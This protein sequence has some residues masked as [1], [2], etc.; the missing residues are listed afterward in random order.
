M[1]LLL[2][3]LAH[4]DTA[5]TDLFFQQEF[6]I[7]K[8]L[9]ALSALILLGY[10]GIVA[11]LYLAQER[12]IYPGSKLPP[13]YKFSFDQPFKEVQIAVPGA[14][15]NALHIM[16]PAP[17]GLL[18]FIHGNGGDL[19]TWTTGADFYR[20]VNYDLF[21]FDYRGYGKSTGKIQSEAQ[22]HADVRAAWDAI[23]PQ[24]RDRNI[25]IVVYGRSLGTGLAVQLAREVDPA[26]LILVSSYT[27]LLAASKR[28]YAIAP[29]WILKYPLRTDAIIGEVKSPILMFHGK[30]D[31]LIPYTD[32]E[33]LRKHVRTP[34][35]L[36]FVDGAGHNDIHQF[37]VYLEAL[38]ARLKS[39]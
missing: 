11:A 27:S 33:Q 21:I 2:R 36:L 17:R 13:D 5:V 16:Q 39:L 15:L 12:I 23:A 29:D 26:L 1:L 30:Q 7:A 37:P 10:A 8:I 25:P 34:S 18:F 31:E 3:V 20:Q 9:I 6:S 24:Y 4:A 14:S 22:L 32:S 35:S 28:A 38:A 19:S